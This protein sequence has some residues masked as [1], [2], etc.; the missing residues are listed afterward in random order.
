MGYTLVAAAAQNFVSST[1]GDFHAF[2]GQGHYLGF[3][4]YQNATEAMVSS[5]MLYAATCF[6][7]KTYTQNANV[8]LRKNGANA[9]QVAIDNTGGSWIGLAPQSDSFAQGDLIALQWL[10]GANIWSAQMIVQWGAATQHAAVYGSV[11]AGTVRASGT[12]F[13]N[14]AQAYLDNTWNW[15]S[16]L[17]PYCQQKLGEGG[18]LN[19]VGCTVQSNTTTAASQVA[20]DKN[21]IGQFSVSIGAGLT[22]AFGI[23]TQATTAAAGDLM[24]G[25]AVIGAG[26]SIGFGWAGF[27]MSNL[28]GA[29]DLWATHI[30]M[31][32]ATTSYCAPIGLAAQGWSTETTGGVQVAHGFGLTISGLTTYIQ[33]NA[34]TAVSTVNLRKNAANANGLLAI[35]A[36]LTGWFTDTGHRDFYLSTDLA[37]T[38]WTT[39]AGG[40]LTPVMTGLTETPAATA[41]NALLAVGN[42]TATTPTP[43]YYSPFA[44]SPT[45]LTNAAE[46]FLQLP[47]PIPG[48]LSRFT[49]M[50]GANAATILV[51][52]RKNNANAAEYSRNDLAGAAISPNTDSF[53]VGDLIDIYWSASTGTVQ[54]IQAQLATT[55][56]HGAVY[57]TVGGGNA[58]AGGSTVY[59]RL[60]VGLGVSVG[61]PSYVTQ[62]KALTAGM[63]R[64]MA[65]NIQNTA[66]TAASTA[67]FYKNSAVGNETVTIGAGLTGTF[68]DTA[69]NDWLAIGDLYGVQI[70]IGAGGL[71]VSAACIGFQNLDTA[72]H[73]QWTSGTS[74]A[75]G[76]TLYVPLY[77]S[78]SGFASDALAQIAHGYPCALSN[79]TVYVYGNATTAASTYSS[80]KNGAAGN[81]SVSI[82]AGLTGYFSDTLN[83]DGLS[84]TDMANFMVVNGGGGTLQCWLAGTKETAPAV[85]P[86][87]AGFA[88]QGVSNT[89]GTYVPTSGYIV[90]LLGHGYNAF[91][92]SA[93]WQLSP[94]VPVSFL[95]SYLAAPG[96]TATWGLQGQ[97]NIT[98]YGPNANNSTAPAYNPVTV[99]AGDR[100]GLTESNSGGATMPKL[101]MA[102]QG[103]GVYAQIYGCCA[104]SATL[105][106]AT[107]YNIG[108]CGPLTPST[109]GTQFLTDIKI[110]QPGALKGLSVN[111]TSNA[112]TAAS[113]FQV[114]KN[115]LLTTNQL[116]TVGAGL[117]GGFQDTTYVDLVASQD[118]VSGY[119]N[120]GAG[121][122]L[123]LS[124]ILVGYINNVAPSGEVWS[125]S[126]GTGTGGQW[127][128]CLIGGQGYGGSQTQLN[129]PATLSGLT[130]SV[131]AN[132]AT[133]VSNLAIHKNAAPSTPSGQ[134][135]VVGAGLTGWFT[136]T[137]HSDAMLATDNLDFFFNV[138]AGGSVTWQ[139]MGVTVTAPTYPLGN[140]L[141]AA[142]ST[143]P[144]NI[145][146]GFFS[147]LVG[148]G[149]MG[150]A[151]A[152]WGTE[153][154]S[155]VPAPFP[156][157]CSGLTAI[158][159]G[160]LGSGTAWTAQ[161][162]KNGA[163]ANQAIS[164]L[165]ASDTTHTDY[166][167][168]GDLL[169]L[170]F[171]PAAPGAFTAGF[172]MTMRANGQQHGAIYGANGVNS[173]SAATNANNYGALHTLGAFTTTLAN[174]QLKAGVAG[175]VQ[176]LAFVLYTNTSTVAQTFVFEKN[177]AVGNQ[178]V[179]FG[180]G[181]TGA[182]RDTTNTDTLAVGDLYNWMASVAGTGTGAW[183]ISAAIVGFLNPVSAANDIFANVGA[184][185][186]YVPIGTEAF[187][188]PYG[189]NYPAQTTEAPAQYQ[190]GYATVLSNLSVYLRSNGGT[191]TS[192][193]V[194]RL[195]GAT[196]QQQVIMGAGLTGWFTDKV[197]Y[198]SYAASDYAD[199]LIMPGTGT[200]NGPLVVWVGYVQSAPQAFTGTLAITE[201]GAAADTTN[202]T[203][204]LLAPITEFGSSADTQDASNFTAVQPIQE[205][206]AATDIEDVGA[207]YPRVIQEA[208]NAQ[209]TGTD[210]HNHLALVITESAP[211]AGDTVDARFTPLRAAVAETGAGADVTD[212]NAQFADAIAETGAAAADTETMFPVLPVTIAESGAATDW[213]DGYYRIF[214]QVTE[215]G[216]AADVTDA[217]VAFFSA[218]AEAG[219]AA[220]APDGVNAIFGLTIREIGAALD[221]PDANISITC[222]IAASGSAQ[223]Q[224]V[225]T[226][227]T[228]QT[229]A[230]T[231]NAYDFVALGGWHF[232]DIA[233][234]GNASEQLMDAYLILPNAITEAGAAADTVDDLV[235]FLVNHIVE[236]GAAADATDMTIPTYRLQI[237][238]AGS[239]ADVVDVV[240]HILAGI[241]EEQGDALDT[242][243][244]K[245]TLTAVIQEIG[246]ALDQSFPLGFKA[247]AQ[248]LTLTAR[249]VRA[250]PT[251]TPH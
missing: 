236:Q 74:P 184:T 7:L 178:G 8:Q 126:G 234:T 89:T 5:P 191:D 226:I 168:T 32:A 56:P 239:A 98:P 185:G 120:V 145:Q 109:G 42:A 23:Y 91:Q 94:V 96:A 101:Q 141:I 108:L 188:P 97:K 113:T 70:V 125:F 100:F 57:G 155:A 219:A 140:T 147:F 154:A 182:F 11:G 61:P 231:G 230:E 222:V 6:G 250:P 243:D 163:Y 179:T 158:Q 183:G 49:I 4:G 68:Q 69:N 134:S 131:N 90:P 217:L 28:P 190:F 93:N 40:A 133:A 138:G 17:Q 164:N 227:Q 159:G 196:G 65:V 238:E 119:A 205:F 246:H 18:S 116:V 29:N 71:G 198:D 207:Y 170:W 186:V 135:A 15:S 44:G 24:S 82:G 3:T 83:T 148:D 115:T 55:S 129:V 117:T 213:Q 21:A 25:R 242:V 200:G 19:R 64:G 225:A 211:P 1:P 88:L 162:R 241:I 157:A 224:P 73:D 38:M 114:R 75:A 105:A 63:V 249:I 46:S 78:S 20:V 31:A 45:L 152:F 62:T 171:N 181:L 43:A 144:A 2:Q 130:V 220:D 85:S 33:A 10:S 216:A 151:S 110:G 192:A 132:T 160:T 118:V 209:D 146:Q 99:L 66:T 174:V 12:W 103:L 156:F 124:Y 47:M 187:V 233:E 92:A 35:G 143:G 80:R 14:F 27:G 221:A 106:A 229:I 139:R 166:Y 53:V 194:S 142:A 149:S 218:V 121:G 48:T 175:V 52:L 122:A 210:L 189:Y 102:I 232:V 237:A 77:G 197:N 123:G 13:F 173:I 212:I 206:G 39:G 50:Q 208:G 215:A 248:V 165:Q 169:A 223:D 59:V 202:R 60:W 235:A 67:N 167:A 58:Q 251:P 180:V 41:G 37:N 136:D 244:V 195:N 199:T 34:T 95:A 72:T 137:T 76:A 30:A 203:A 204:N 87:A 107:A 86:P 111:I 54:R 51:Y 112:A 172:R 36:G 240:Q 176:G 177:G 153:A 84:A 193:A 128:F 104:L 247:Y 201:A 228:T 26:G 150:N 161:L 16:T 22:G 214:G 81:Q 127:E 245:H 9:N 79:L